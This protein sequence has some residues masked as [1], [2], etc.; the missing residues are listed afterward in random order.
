MT[1]AAANQDM[2]TRFRARDWSGVPD[3]SADCRACKIDLDLEQF[4]VM[5]ETRLR[6]FRI[7]L[8]STDWD[9]VFEAFYNFAITPWAG[10]S[11]H[12]QWIDNTAVSVDD[13]VVLSSRLNVRF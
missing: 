4:H 6:A 11:A 12:A 2:L 13:T 1:L 10:L 7:T 5:Y 8:P 9:G 3:A